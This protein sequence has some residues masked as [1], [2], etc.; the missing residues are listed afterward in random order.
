MENL[1]NVYAIGDIAMIEGPDWVAK[2]GHIAEVMARNTAYNISQQIKGSEK[3]K[4]Y[5]GHLNILC[6]MDTGNGAALTYRKDEKDFIIPLPKVGHWLKQGW[7]FYY[8]NSKLKKF[9][10]IPGM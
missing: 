7:G 8:R 10:R 4:G 9:P 2:Q 3:R 5:K 6:V 1:K